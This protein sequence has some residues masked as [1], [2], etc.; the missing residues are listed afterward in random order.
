[1]VI[2]TNEKWETNNGYWIR[3]NQRSSKYFLSDGTKY[4]E[5]LLKAPSKCISNYQ[6]MVEG[7]EY[8]KTVESFYSFLESEFGF[9]KVNETVNGNAFYDV[10]Y[11]DSEKA[12]SI[13]YENIEAHLEVI[14]FKL[15][16]GK[17]PDYDDKSQTLHL[18]RLNGLVMSKADK[19]EISSNARYFS[20][21]NT[22]DELGRKLLKGAKELRLCLKYF[23]QLQIA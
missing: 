20:K 7:T 19:D 15:L 13:S 5:E 11:K 18:N 1:M 4:D 2:A 3:P 22:E 21:Y 8:I 14:V 10:E 16:N 9:K 12:I 17:M 6:V 23:D